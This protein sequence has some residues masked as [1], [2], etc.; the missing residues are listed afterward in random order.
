MI[1]LRPYQLEVIERVRDVLRTGKRRVVVVLPTGA[2]KTV[3]TAH[4]VGNSVERGKRS[5]FLAPRRELVRQT[6]AKLV[7]NGLA[8]SQVGI[9][10][11]GTSSRLLDAAAPSPASLDDQRLWDLYARRRPQAAVQVA[12]ID[13][14]RS[15]ALPPADLVIVDEC[16]RSISPGCREILSHYGTS[17]ILGLTATP[18]RADGRGLDE[19][20]EDLVV[21]ASP[22]QLV[23]EGFLVAPKAF[24]VPKE[25]MPDLSGVKIKG[26]DYDAVQLGEACDRAELVGDIV[27]HWQ[28]L[29]Q[30]VRTV[31]FA[32]S[33]SHSK[34]IA[35]RFRE[36]GIAAEHLDGTTP[37]ADRDAILRRLERGET[38]V[39]VNVGV[40]CEGWDMP[41]VKCLVLARPTKSLGLYLQ[42]A[43]RI[44]RPFEGLGAIILDHAGCVTEH[45]FPTQD[46]EFSLEGRKK[47]KNAASEPPAKTCPQCFAILPSA[48]RVCDCGYEFPAPERSALEEKDGTLV[49]LPGPKVKRVNPAALAKWDAIV[50]E[51]HKYNAEL[52]VPLEPKW[53]VRRWRLLYRS[54]PPA[55]SKWPTLTEE[56]MA[57]IARAKE[58]EK[59]PLF[60]APIASPITEPPVQREPARRAELVEVA[61]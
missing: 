9:V 7:R 60:A 48:L 58:A 54:W 12:S 33:V 27:E 20:Y 11:A 18:Y 28:R 50:A 19:L 44:L 39:V 52:P 42:M 43:G 17:I 15:R 29:A 8:P 10:M 40:L 51:W 41:S 14:L 1:P 38:R 35:A 4:I 36:A 61:W 47:S 45:G 24:G 22:S 21:G 26:G 6:F 25:S 56:Q 31:V 23:A 55:G 49:E 2:G 13:T 46:R 30:G 16:H 53:C 5:V 57:A 32:A 37:T 34:R 59:A 3:V